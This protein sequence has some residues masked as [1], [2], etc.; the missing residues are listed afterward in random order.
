M[1]GIVVTY[2]TCALFEAMLASLRAH[3]PA[4]P[5]VVV[6]GSDRRDACYKFVQAIKDP[7]TTTYQLE[8]NIGH[9]L[10]LHFA[11][12]R[13][14][15]EQLLLMDSDIVLHGDPTAAMLQLL[16]PDVYAVGELDTVG[17]NGLRANPVRNVPFVQPY[18]MLLSRRQYYKYNRFVHH[19]TPSYK[20][21]VQI[22]QQG[23]SAKLLQAFPVADYVFHNWGGT[24]KYNASRG[25]HEIP[26]AWET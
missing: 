18:F 19:G 25:Q 21:M 8:K 3:L 4:L 13:T 7:N 14:P 16:G 1:T 11:I 23:Q 6:D 12:E 22:F 15:D 9:G 2:N 26:N 10:G 20:A 24:R 5:L 17:A